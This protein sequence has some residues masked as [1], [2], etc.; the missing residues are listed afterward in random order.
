MSHT[1]IP[2]EQYP[3]KWIFNHKD[4]PVSEKDKGHIHP[5]TQKSAML[6]WN[7]WI[8]NKS[9][10]SE[11][12]DNGDWAAKQDA[13]KNM[14]HWQSAWDSEAAELPELLTHFIDWPDNA[15]VYFC[16]DKYQ[17][18]E[19]TW[20]V[21]VRNWKCFLFFDDGPLLISPKQK[22][23]VLFHQN[24]QYQVGHRG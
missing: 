15:I 6:V 7:K 24:G 8:S 16:Y 18:I 9:S 3:R 11:Q 14:D 17:V 22:Q 12:F 13:W 10:R 21:F 2:L 1:Y 5:L 4:L 19:T 20:E 23:A